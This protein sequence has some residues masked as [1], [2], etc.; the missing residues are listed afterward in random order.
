MFHKA[1]IKKL[2]IYQSSLQ[3]KCT[4]TFFSVIKSWPFLHSKVDK[5]N[6]KISSSILL[7]TIQDKTS[8]YVLYN[9]KGYLFVHGTDQKKY[10]KT[11]Q[12]V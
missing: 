6:G 12:N 8:R 3:K 2:I 7:K 5:T 10:Q 9:K 1:N 11:H 4:I